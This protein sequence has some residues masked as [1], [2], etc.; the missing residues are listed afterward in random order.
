MLADSETERK[1]CCME[2]D[3]PFSGYPELVKEREKLRRIQDFEEKGATGHGGYRPGAGK[4]K[5]HQKVIKL[6]MLI[7][8]EDEP[9]LLHVIQEIKAMYGRN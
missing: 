8:K 6:S 7:N 3:D 4:P 1:P 9:D 2:L 5:S